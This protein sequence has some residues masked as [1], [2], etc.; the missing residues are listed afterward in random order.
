MSDPQR[1]V[2]E[3]HEKVSDP[4]GKNCQNQALLS[5]GQNW[6][7]DLKNLIYCRIFGFAKLIVGSAAKATDPEGKKTNADP[8]RMKVVHC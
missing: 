6:K 2:L 4:D 5:P 1:T 7:A 3:P 8:Y